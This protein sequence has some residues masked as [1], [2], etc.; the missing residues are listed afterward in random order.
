MATEAFTSKWGVDS[1]DFTT[2]DIAPLAIGQFVAT[3]VLL[4]IARPAFLLTK[5]N[6]TRL[7]E[8]SWFRALL[9]AIFIVVGTYMY[10]YCR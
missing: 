3:L 1:N 10:P 7:A 2:H 5:R 4:C 6:A 8:F 9:T